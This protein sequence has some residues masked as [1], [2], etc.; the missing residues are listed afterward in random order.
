VDS[1]DILYAPACIKRFEFC[2]MR[3]ASRHWCDRVM[4][5]V[6]EAIGERLLFMQRNDSRPSYL[7]A[8]LV[9][10]SEL[11]ELLDEVYLDALQPSI[12]FART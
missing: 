1:V 10:A 2:S 6:K 8:G 7:L 5:K 12:D 11:R 9:E 3:V 4:H